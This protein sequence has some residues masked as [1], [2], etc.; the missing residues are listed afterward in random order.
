M[1]ACVE[2][3]ERSGTTLVLNR[4][5]GK[6]AFLDAEHEDLARSIERSL[7][8]SE[9]ASTP[10][11]FPKGHE[12]LTR[13]GVLSSNQELSTHSRIPNKELGLLILELTQACNLG[14]EYCAASADTSGRSLSVSLATSAI[15]EVVRQ[16][17]CANPLTIE[18]SGGEP[19]I[20]FEII[21]S[22]IKHCDHISRIS[23]QNFRFSLQ[24]NG[25]LI[26][27]EIA[28]FLTKYS[29]DVGISL[30]G[31]E[32]VHDKYR[33]FSNGSGSFSQAFS[34][35]EMIKKASGHASILSVIRYPEQYR[36]V[37]E[38]C[39]EAGIRSAKLN[40]MTNLGRGNSFYQVGSQIAHNPLDFA[41]GFMD[42]AWLLVG[43][44]ASGRAPLGVKEN[45]LLHTF[46]TLLGYRNYMCFR[47][48]CG[49]GINQL[50]VDPDGNVHVCQDWRASGAP[51]FG[52]VSEGNINLNSSEFQQ[53]LLSQNRLDYK[54][55]QDCSWVSFCGAC[56]RETMD[57]T[58]SISSASPLCDF[59][60]YVFRECI[61][62]LHEQ[63]SDV[64]QYISGRI[65]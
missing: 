43:D 19:L 25:T 11:G 57:A 2:L 35:L 12:E 44:S 17:L 61:W 29:V 22:I 31:P 18:L 33:C 46:L 47:T 65:S 51:S 16:R 36:E 34:G 42:M 59:Y 32:Q 4:L 38:F 41:K 6:W 39:A 7:L 55:C 63:R 5:T 1:R 56:P 26:T 62:M 28:E 40:H 52:N 8:G 24:T 30:D 9:E 37:A 58:G 49:A 53:M 13:I 10:T 23:G 45:N 3:E 48:P 20:C 14:C 60:S 50:T 21:K 27:Q 64:V 54:E 15:D